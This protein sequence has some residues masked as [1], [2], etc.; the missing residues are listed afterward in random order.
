MQLTGCSRAQEGEEKTE[1]SAGNVVDDT[2]DFSGNGSWV[3]W[4][5]AGGNWGDT[6]LDGIGGVLER[7]GNLDKRS[8]D[9]GNRSLNIGIRGE[10]LNLR[11]VRLCRRD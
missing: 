6:G 8:L 2:S 3:R 7:R 1:E 4:E 10:W 11:N 9:G 5:L